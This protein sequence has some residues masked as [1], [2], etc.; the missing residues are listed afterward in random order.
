MNKQPNIKISLSLSDKVIEV[1]TWV[2]II[3]IWVII[4]LKYS[5]LNE[6]IPTHYNEKGEADRFGSKAVIL[7]LP[8]IATVLFAGLTLLNKYPHIFN[9]PTQ[10]TEENAKY[11]Y[12]IATRLVRYLKFIIVILFTYITLHVIQYSNGDTEGLGIWF[13][14]LCLGLIFLPL[15]YYIALSKKNKNR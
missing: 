13:L 6:I 5:H 11:Q 3:F 10:I 7:L 8:I 9:Y 2:T 15:F 14:P 1:I 4:L 12:Q